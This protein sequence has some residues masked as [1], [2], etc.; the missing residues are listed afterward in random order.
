MG[1]KLGSGGALAEQVEG[2]QNGQ[3][4]LDQRVELLIED[5]EV[6]RLYGSI[7]AALGELGENVE[8]RANIKT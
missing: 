2:F 3:A 8:I 6:V 4:G 1:R 7:G 5:Q